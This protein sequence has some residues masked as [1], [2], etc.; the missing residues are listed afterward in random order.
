[1]D[2]KNRRNS[3]L[4]TPGGMLIRLKNKILATLRIDPT[5]LNLLLEKYA[6]KLN[7][8]RK[9]Y[10]SQSTR[11]NLAAALNKDYI[12]IN[13]FFGFLMALEPKSVKISVTVTLK[14]GEEYT[15][16][17]TAIFRTEEPAI[18]KDKEDKEEKDEDK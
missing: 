13:K 7:G 2:N 12:S 6:I 16:D 17:E 10:K 9:D 8:G 15:V 5:R 1:M 11:T 14:N 18:I 3:G 4:N